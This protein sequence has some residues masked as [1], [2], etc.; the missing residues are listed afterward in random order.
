MYTHYSPH[1]I[2]ARSLA[3]IDSEVPEPRPFAGDEWIVVRRMIHTSADFALL[4][5]VRFHPEAV[6]AGIQALSQGAEIITDTMMALA[7][8]PPRRLEPLGCAARCLMNDPEVFRRAAAEGV[9]RAWAAVDEAM[10]R[11]GADIFVIGNAPTAL[12]RLLDRVMQGAPAPRLVVGMPVGFVNAAESKEL[13]L[14]QQTIPYITIQGR[15][16]GSSLAASVVNALANLA[17]ARQ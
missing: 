12:F 6:A 3:I 1:E 16:G 4:D 9:T 17:L 11:G 10:D 5:S 7:G 14:A 8:M 13:L 15:K 2:E